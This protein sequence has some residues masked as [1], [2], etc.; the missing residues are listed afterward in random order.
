MGIR[1][2]FFR[3]LFQ[4]SLTELGYD[5]DLFIEAWKKARYLRIKSKLMSACDADYGDMFWYEE[6]G[7]NPYKN[8]RGEEITIQI[9]KMVK[10]RYISHLHSTFCSICEDEQDNK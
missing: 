9:V 4:S 5:Y 3:V 2:P 10:C 6:Y 8:L 7:F 1:K